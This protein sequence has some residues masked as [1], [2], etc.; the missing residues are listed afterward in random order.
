MPPPAGKTARKSAAGN[1]RGPGV[2]ES[3]L[4]LRSIKENK[5]FED[6]LQSKDRVRQLR[7][8]STS[9]ISPTDREKTT[10]DLISLFNQRSS[11]PKPKTDVRSASPVTMVRST[12]TGHRNSPGVSPVSS[13]TKHKPPMGVWKDDKVGGSLLKPREEHEQTGSPKDLAVKRRPKK[14]GERPRLQN[15]PRSLIIP[16]QTS[17]DD[18]ISAHLNQAHS[19]TE[20]DVDDESKD[21][22]ITKRRKFVREEKPARRS[23]PVSPLSPALE[24][25]VES[26]NPSLI[27]RDIDIDDSLKSTSR[28]SWAENTV[29]FAEHKAEDP[30]I[31]PTVRNVSATVVGKESVCGEVSQPDVVNDSKEPIAGIYG[32]AESSGRL[33][34][35]VRD[36]PTVR[37]DF[38]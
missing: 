27:V 26:G 1:R 38:Y 23:L 21:E 8:S 33:S 36:T 14:A 15:R 19:D 30:D 7:G 2:A 29:I 31:T 37:P 35:P 17:L 12:R 32:A 13:P 18:L 4:D 9:S 5:A 34:P 16:T 10:S 11:T 28:K 24:T 25:L 6:D 3:Q 20:L 22:Q